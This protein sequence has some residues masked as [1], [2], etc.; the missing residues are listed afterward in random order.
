MPPNHTDDWG[1]NPFS[2]EFSSLPKH[3]TLF[4]FP[5]GAVTYVPNAGYQGTDSFT[6]TVADDGYLRSAPATVHIAIGTVSPPG[7]TSGPETVFAVGRAANFAVTTVGS[8]PMTI[9]EAGVLPSGVTFTDNDDGTASLAGTAAPGTTGTYRLTITASNDVQPDATQAFTLT[10]TRGGQSIT[11]STPA[12]STAVY[13]TSFAVAATGGGSG[14]PVIYSSSGACSNIGTFRFTM[15]SG[16]GTCS[17]KYNQAGDRDYTPAQQVIETVTAER[18]DQT[19][20]IDTR[21]PANAVYGSSFSVGA[22]A[23]GGAVS[24]SSAGAC[25]NSGATFT[26]TSGT[27]ACTVEFGQAGDDNYSAA[28]RVFESVA[29]Q[30]ASQTITVDTHAP[31]S[32]V[33]G[34]SFAV[35]AHA[36]GGVVSFSSAGACSNSGSSFTMT[37]AKGTC[38]VE[39]DQAGDDNYSVAPTVFESVAAQKASQAITVDTHAPASAVYGASF[40]VAAHA[41]GGGVS[42][43]SSGA[44]S[45]SGSTFTMTSGSGTCSVSYEQV[46][47][48]IDGP[49]PTVIESVTAQKASQAITV[50][51]HAPASAV[52]GTSFTVAAHAP[53]GACVVLEFRRLLEPGKHVHHDERHRD[54]H[55]QL[56]PGRQ[57]QLR[58][59]ADGDR[60]GDRA[61]GEP[62]DRVHVV[63][64]E[65]GAGRRLV[66]ADG[67]RRRLGQ[68]VRVQ[69]RLVEQRGRL[70]PDE[71]HCL[72]HRCR[73]VHRRREPGRRR[74][75]LRRGPDAADDHGRRDAD[76]ERGRARL[77]DRHV[78]AGRAAITRNECPR[79]RH[80][81]RRRE[82]HGS[83][84]GDHG[85]ASRGRRQLHPR[86]RVGL[87]G[88]VDHGNDRHRCPRRRRLTDTVPGQH[89]HRPRVE[90]EQLRR[91]RVR[92]QHGARLAQ[93]HRQHRDASSARRRHRRLRGQ[94]SHGPRGSPAVAS[95]IEQVPL[96]SAQVLP[97]W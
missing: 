3:G 66:H 55:G 44:C 60:V 90:H 48:D 76:P 47:N 11:V 19:I 70:L 31:A 22:H 35:A 9:S 21:A 65:P 16:T 17:V 87:D 72:V 93:D 83:R 81:R 78:G 97:P 85:F 40:T 45:N 54:V 27:G 75:L 32:A 41:P 24:F 84:R 37:S 25:S 67:D 29:A 43:S 13:G 7:I 86:V 80:H 79:L 4:G 12:P 62:D 33:Y 10:V 38:T 26:V 2:I 74:E 68:P 63:A 46:G 39:F 82:P 28:P 94:H 14:N 69:N 64:A 73:N 71:R 58:A 59:G 15:T 8:P 23:P 91:C 30:K 42:F 88:P 92:R 34:A 51:T 96:S 61:E 95:N 53:V 56:R 5:F 36:P 18:A 57:R 20:A 1:L 52:Y 89:D 50:D 6:Y 77:A 49:A